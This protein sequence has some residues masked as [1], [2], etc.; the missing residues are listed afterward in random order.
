MLPVYGCQCIACERAR[1]NPVYSL[2]K[3]SAYISD[4]GWNLLIDAN[5]EDLLRRFP[6]G[7]IDSIVLTHYHMDHVQSL[8]DLRWGLNLSIPVFGPDDPVGCDDLFKHPGILDFK[9]ARQPFEH[10][11]W[12]DIRITPVPL[13]HSKPCLGYVFEYRGKRIA[14]LTDTVD[15]PEKVKQWFEGNLM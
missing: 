2:G 8:F 9:A 10:F 14:Y 15:L 12:R 6:A 1:E 7:S 3:T 4:Q 13:I 5:A 11:Y